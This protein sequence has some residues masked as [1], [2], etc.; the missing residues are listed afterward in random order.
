M[1]L[2]SSPFTILPLHLEWKTDHDG[3]PGPLHL[4]LAD[5]RRVC[6]LQSLAG[7]GEVCGNAAPASSYAD[8]VDTYATNMCTSEMT[9]AIRRLQTAGMT[10]EEQKLT[11]FFR[12]NLLKLSNWPEWDEC[13]DAQLDAHHASGAML[14]HVPRP[15]ATA[16]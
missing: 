11:K 12:R 3:R 6:A 4:R 2:P 10:D 1:T 15:F 13:F 16:G 14:P 5:L 8:A 7:E 9:A